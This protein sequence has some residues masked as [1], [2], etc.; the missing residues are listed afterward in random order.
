MNKIVR[1]T[2][3]SND[4]YFLIVTAAEIEGGGGLYLD[5]NSIFG[6]IAL[7]N[8]GYQVLVC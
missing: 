1:L 7:C 4:K 6:K 8:Q 5:I 2:Y 3:L